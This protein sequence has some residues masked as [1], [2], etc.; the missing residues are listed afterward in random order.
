MAIGMLI[1]IAMARNQRIRQL[2]P[3]S[4]GFEGSTVCAWCEKVLTLGNLAGPLSHGLCLSCIVENQLLP[5]DR[6]EQMSAAELDRL[7]FGVIRLSHDGLILSYNQAESAISSN[8]A[9][10]VIGK[11]FFDDVAPCTKTSGFYGQY[12]QLKRG[13]VNGRKELSYV[14]RFLGGALLVKI[15][16]LYDAKTQ[17]TLLLVQPLVRECVAKGKHSRPISKGLASSVQTSELFRISDTCYLT[18]DKGQVGLSLK[19]LHKNIPAEPCSSAA[20]QPY[21]A[22]GDVSVLVNYLLSIIHS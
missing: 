19:H 18:T 21:P 5:S 3:H 11:N 15:V 13:N 20:D 14:F 17:T 16:L 7:P 12:L 4:D 8:K 22:D 2:V 10:N 9:K 1:Q 6:L